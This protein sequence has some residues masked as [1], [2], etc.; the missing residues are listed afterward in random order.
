MPTV[1]PRA[2]VRS[3]VAS[4]RS[5]RPSTEHRGPQ[6]PVASVNAWQLI[7]RGRLRFPT[8]PLN[9]LGYAAPASYSVILPSPHLTLPI[10]LL[11]RG[12]ALPCQSGL[13]SACFIAM[14]PKQAETGKKPLSLPT[15]PPSFEPALGWSRVLND[16]AMDKVRPMLASSFNEWGETPAWL[17]S[18]PSMARAVTEVPIFIDALSAGLIPPFSAFFNAVLEHYQIHMLH[19]D[20]Q[21]VTLLAVFAFLWE[22]WW[23]SLLSWPCSAISSHCI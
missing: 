23:A 9:P 5:Q 17:A 10:S 14:S 18:H 13:R 12:P 11:P 3:G 16:E 22:P 6:K 15:A 20:P 7:G 19:L 4:R 2:K 8:L 1:A 21:S